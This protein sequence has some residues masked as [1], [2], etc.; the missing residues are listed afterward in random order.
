MTHSYTTTTTTIKLFMDNIFK[1]HGI[2]DNTV[3][4]QDAI[5]T[6]EKI[7]QVSGSKLLVSGAGHPQQMG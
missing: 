2:L 1:L 5:F 6:R 4:D 3:S 7:F